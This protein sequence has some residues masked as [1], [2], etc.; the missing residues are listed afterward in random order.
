MKTGGISMNNY[1]LSFLPV[2]LLLVSIV[3]ITACGGHADRD[4]HEGHGHPAEEAGAFHGAVDEGQENVHIGEEHLI[5]L[6]STEIEEFG[7]VTRPV[8]GGELTRRIS[9]PGEV[10]LNEDKLVHVVPRLSGVV[11]QVH[12]SLG[13]QVSEGQVMAVIESW[14]LADA[15]AQHVAATIRLNLAEARFERERDLFLQKITSLED[16]LAAKQAMIEARIAEENADQK[17]R[18]LD[19]S[20]EDHGRGGNRHGL[21][22]ADYRIIAPL[23]GTVIDKHISLG[24]VLKADTEVFLL[25]DLR[26]VWVDLSVYQKDLPFVRAG[27]RITLSAGHG[28]PD[29][30]AEIGY[31]GALVGEATRTALARVVLDN[32]SGLWRPGLFVTGRMNAH[33]RPVELMVAIDAVQEI[34]EEPA[35]FVKDGESGGFRVRHVTVGARDEE[36]TEI[37]S[38]LR[39]GEVYVSEGAFLLKSNLLKGSFGHGHVH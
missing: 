10:K 22:S 31:V 25:A 35:V 19:L 36:W 38:G 1:R 39:P 2:L 7:I 9:L 27:D 30:E 24:E 11:R 37:T 23:S 20:E 12:S 4:S 13:D 34:H 18:A 15:E 32:E 6:S 21:P 29:T 3:S 33:S 26:T 5:E 16:F 8:G 14:E 28:I 17:H